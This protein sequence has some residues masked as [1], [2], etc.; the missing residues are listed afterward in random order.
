MATIQLEA[1]QVGKR[2]DLSDLIA[3]ADRKNTPF[4]NQVPK[5]A[6]PK[7]VVFHRGLLNQGKVEILYEGEIWCVQEESCFMP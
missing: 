5:G 2:E 1:D 6:I 7:N 4:Y 3:T